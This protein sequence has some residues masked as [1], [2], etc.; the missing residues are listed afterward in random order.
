MVPH[1][2]QCVP[3]RFEFA[4]STACSSV[5][6]KDELSELGTVPELAKTTQHSSTSNWNG[7]LND[8][9]GLIETGQVQI[10][11]SQLKS[12]CVNLSCILNKFIEIVHFNF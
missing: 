12:L 5:G 11:S 3:E 6:E 8:A 4:C 2:H 9:T 7:L 1:L 10:K